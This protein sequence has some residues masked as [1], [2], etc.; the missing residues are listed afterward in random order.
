M[1]QPILTSIK[2]IILDL[3]GVIYDIRYE[4]IADVFTSYG[5]ENFTSYYTQ[6]N[7][8][9]TIDLFEEGKISPAQFRDYIRSISP[10]QLSDNQIDNAW[11]AI[12]IDVPEKRV[13][14][15]DKLSKKYRL[16][17]FSNTNQINYDA[18]SEYLMKKY[19]YDIF[20]TYFEK[21]YWSHTLHIRKPKIEGFQTICRE[22]NLIPS[23]TLFIDDT[24]RHIEGAKRA[25]LN[26]FLLQGD[27]TDIN[28]SV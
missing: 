6:A 21:S 4:N 16:F 18:F 12:M 5:I 2:N 11:N 9:D 10:I 19:G 7:Q 8:S 25:G 28:F 26:T 14:L 3:G 13:Q 24:E 1:Q 27:L 23:E 15:I 22:N 20:D 17:L